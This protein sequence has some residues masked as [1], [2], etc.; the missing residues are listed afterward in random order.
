VGTNCNYKKRKASEWFRVFRGKIADS[1]LFVNK[2]FIRRFLRF[3]LVY[4]Q[5]IS[6][7]CTEKEF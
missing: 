4:Y 5:S 1:S 6:A 2:F 7:K 3:M